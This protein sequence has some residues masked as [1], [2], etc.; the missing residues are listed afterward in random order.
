M[1]AQDDAVIQDGGSLPQEG[2]QRFLQ[3]IFKLWI[4]PEIER[5]KDDG[6]IPPEFVLNQA[7]VIFDINKPPS[8]RLNDEV[9]CV[10]RAVVKNPVQFG[11]VI[12]VNKFHRITNIEL[13][14]DD[15][16]SG[17]VTIIILPES[18]F[19]SANFIY[20]SSKVETT[21]NSAEK[22]LDSARA[23]MVSKLPRP[24]VENSF[25]SSELTSKA[26]LIMMPD[27]K[28]LQAKSHGYI[29]S[30]IN[31][32]RKLGNIDEEF[33][34]NFNWLGQMREKA[35]YSYEQFDIEWERAEKAILVIEEILKTVRARIPKRYRVDS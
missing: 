19:I 6:R 31:M 3:Q 24:F 29:S 8:V 18:I 30:S 26:F 11:D 1:P 32:H 9:K 25:A 21:L 15:K 27:K 33:C 34:D 28:A 17:H 23:S 5:R 12:G 2:Q 7:Q 14:E 20:N 16:D 10:M 13:T 35:R 4:D 22:F